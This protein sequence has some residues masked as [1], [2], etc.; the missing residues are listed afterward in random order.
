MGKN[1]YLN[2]ALL[3]AGLFF[4]LSPLQSQKTA[5]IVQEPSFL[6]LARFL[7]A[8]PDLR[9]WQPKGPPQHYKG[10]DLFLYIDG[11]AE[12][13]REY[14][15]K[16]VI[17]QD[18]RDT[19]NRSITLEIFEMANAESAYGMFSFKSGA[20]GISYSIGHD[21]RLEDYYLSFWKGPLLITLIGFD[22]SAECREGILRLAR[23]AD[24][25]IPLTGTRPSLIS[26]LPKEW[27]ESS[28]I[29]YLKGILGLNNIHAFFPYDL[30]RFKE[31]LASE[32][33]SSTLFIF[34]Y[35]N[36][37]EAA[38]RFSEVKKAFTK[39]PSY[40]NLKSLKAN[41]FES[42]DAKGNIL[43]VEL[44]GDR[45]RITLTKSTVLKK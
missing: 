41:D 11:G 4:F 12:I 35:A 8:A 23:A 38:A 39:S 44:Q 40:K 15:F 6:D 29:I 7:P 9:G 28:R 27:A 13:Y 1:E 22:A 43:R 30:F 26:V 33:N 37:E 2:V 14:G 5:G 34:R 36:T 19:K 45:I 31:G 21:A 24:A 17:V 25:R 18:Y 42:T 16:Q 32:R 3:I 10:E 20:K